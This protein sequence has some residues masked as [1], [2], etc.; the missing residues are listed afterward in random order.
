MAG[1]C[2]T[3]I[4][5]IFA[6]GL[7]GLATLGL[8][9]EAWAQPV[10]RAQPV[11]PVQPA[12]PGQP[13]DGAT[14]YDAA[15]EAFERLPETDRIAIQDALVWTGDAVSAPD[16]TFGRRTYDSVVAYQ[17]RLRQAPTGTLTRPA[18]AAL[19][20]T[21]AR[22]RTETGFA[23]TTDRASGIRIGIPATLL[24]K[25]APNASGG[26]RYQ[27]QDDRITLDTRALPGDE[28]ALRDLYERNLAL[29][30][31]GRNVTYR[32]ARPGFFVISG[33]TASGRFYTRYGQAGGA[34]RGFS[35]GY[36]KAL[37]PSFDRV[38][39]AIANSFE[40]FP[41]GL[42]AP[43]APVAGGSPLPPA[44]ARA[45]AAFSGLAVAARRIL[46]PAAAV[47]LCREPLVDKAPA[48][49]VSVD[50]ARGLAVLEPAGAHRT[51]P[52]AFAA[53]PAAGPGVVLFIAPGEGDRAVAAPAELD[54]LGRIVAPLQ[55]GAAGGVVLDP[56][57]AVVGMVAGLASGRRAVAGLVPPASHPVIAAG[58][59]RAVA[60]ADGPSTPREAGPPR[61]LGALAAGFT[62]AL[63][64][65][66]CAAAAPRP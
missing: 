60:G 2:A 17:R 25:R 46:V 21:G 38:A 13:A 24:P 65:I 53:A 54:G 8:A 9:S 14:G 26:T 59:L 22:A 12:R 20:A 3:W 11:Q 33:E 4:V 57:G 16:G 47:E 6:R 55:D 27:S 29:S 35:I 28:D 66:G 39:L 19:V 61:G 30:A 45:A 18:I 40:P 64:R 51:V 31:P 52:L 56:A 42:A 15:R 34:I 43:P 10:Q 7:L 49:I 50:R 44:A 63:A 62:P 48:R 41:T 32:L 36:D 23:V 37:A 58:D 5:R 1:T